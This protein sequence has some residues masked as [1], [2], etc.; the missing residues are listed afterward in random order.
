MNKQNITKYLD[1]PHRIEIKAQDNGFFVSI[2]DLPG[3]FSQGDTLDE[4]Y[5]MILGAKEAWVLTGALLSWGYQ[6]SFEV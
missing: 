3:C 2:P 6:E 5:V 4:A 1:M